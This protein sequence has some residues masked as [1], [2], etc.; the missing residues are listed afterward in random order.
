MCIK[1]TK[2]NPAMEDYIGAKLLFETSKGVVNGKLR[3]IEEDMGKLVVEDGDELKDV[4]IEDIQKLEIVE[5]IGS[6]NERNKINIKNEALASVEKETES[7]MLLNSSNTYDRPSRSQNEET[8]VILKDKMTEKSF[9]RKIGGHHKTPPSM[10]S[11]EVQMKGSMSSTTE[12]RNNSG[13][14][15]HENGQMKEGRFAP[16]TSEENYRKMMIRAITYFG[17][18]EEELSSIGARQ[19]YRIFSTYFDNTRM[20]V[21]VFVRGDDVFSCMGFILARLLLQNGKASSV[22]CDENFVRTSSYKQAYL[23]SGGTIDSKPSGLANVH[24]YG[25]NRSLLPESKVEA[26][27][28]MYL[29]IPTSEEGEDTRIG[30]CFGSIPSNFRSFG[31]IVYFIDVEYPTALYKEFGLMRP[32]KS[33]I[34]KIK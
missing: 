21:E 29:D 4:F 12:N 2:S 10:S 13:I 22:V 9:A 18:L 7:R 11:V 8:E 32:M 15:G 3:A 1:T 14:K 26:K 24:I 23:N 17:P 27:G 28:I 6:G 31:G 20:R 19:T 30:L 34:Y 33:K 5:E 16:E 25:C